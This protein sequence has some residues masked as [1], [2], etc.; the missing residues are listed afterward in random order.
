MSADYIPTDVPTQEDTT[1]LLV[2]P[3]G[4]D[5]MQASA[6]TASD[7][8]GSTWR[9]VQLSFRLRCALEASC[10]LQPVV[11]DLIA[12]HLD[13]ACNYNMFNMPLQQAVKLD[14]KLIDEDL[15]RIASSMRTKFI[16]M[17]RAGR[18]T[19]DLSGP[20]RRAQANSD[21]GKA[22]TKQQKAMADLLHGE[23]LRA[24]NEN[25]AIANMLL[26]V[27]E[28]HHNR[29]ITQLEQQQLHTVHAQP[30]TEAARAVPCTHSAACG[31]VQPQLNDTTV[32]AQ[33]GCAVFNNNTSNNNNAV[34]S[35]DGTEQVCEDSRDT[36]VSE[37]TNVSAATTHTPTRMWDEAFDAVLQEVL[38][39]TDEAV[40]E[41]IYRDAN[42]A[43]ERR[44]IE[45]LRKMASQFNLDANCEPKEIIDKLPRVMK[46][47]VSAHASNERRRAKLEGFKKHYKHAI[48]LQR[49][50]ALQT[51]QVAAIV[52]DNV[53]HS[54]GKSTSAST[55]AA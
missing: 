4:S 14:A 13:Y 38:T 16:A 46:N 24:R 8:Y 52:L 1:G 9:R 54:D 35:T 27:A 45:Q 34:V 36:N 23:L 12:T 32:A 49:R 48:L 30:A 41:R 40:F 51:G 15:Q 37:C 42:E 19:Q 33:A 26:Q 44:R 6:C 55:P 5:S 11:Y 22:N 17:T 21:S 10:T 18:V 2:A 47:R 7:V 39:E 50:L 53:Q 28:S 31:N 20:R 3:T 43:C 25:V 29:Q